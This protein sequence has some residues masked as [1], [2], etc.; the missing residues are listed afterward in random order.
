MHMRRMGSSR[1]VPP[2]PNV[3][4][5]TVLH[6]SRVWGPDYTRVVHSDRASSGFIGIQD[7]AVT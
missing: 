7:T 4:V 1:K 2:A 6:I 3:R 5:P